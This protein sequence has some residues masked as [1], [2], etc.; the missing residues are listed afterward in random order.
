MLSMKM[1]ARNGLVKL[2]GFFVTW[3]IHTVYIVLWKFVSAYAV[4]SGRWTD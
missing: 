3:D 2:V 1:S 4:F